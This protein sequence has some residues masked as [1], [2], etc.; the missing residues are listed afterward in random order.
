MRFNNLLFLFV[1]L[2]PALCVCGASYGVG[3]RG[4]EEI[5]VPVTVAVRALCEIDASSN[6]VEVLFDGVASGHYQ[7][8]FTITLK[9]TG[10]P[11]S[12]EVSFTS[13]NNV[14]AQSRLLA[15]SMESATLNQPVGVI[16]V[17]SED[18]RSF[19]WN[20]VPVSIPLVANTIKL[21]AGLSL[22]SG[23]P[24]GRFQATGIFTINY[25]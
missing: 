6:N 12:P 19:R 7:Q 17:M 16:Q 25:I 23:A 20:D 5:S 21:V 15:L 13:A 11:A 4:T 2:F 14:D 9:G 10:C 24:A 1:I 22:Y 3:F 18:G 8:S